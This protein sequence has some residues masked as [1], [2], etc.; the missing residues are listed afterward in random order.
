V[1]DKEDQLTCTQHAWRPKT[2]QRNNVSTL[3]S[4]DSFCEWV[5]AWRL[6]STLFTV[7][8]GST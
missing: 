1:T 5:Y 2:W 8:D 6:Y 3:S 7:H 4:G